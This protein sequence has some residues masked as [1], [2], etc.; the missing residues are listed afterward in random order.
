[1]NTGAVRRAIA[2]RI[3]DVV[4]GVQVHNHPPGALPHTPAVVI[5][6]QSYDLFDAFGDAAPTTRWNLVALCDAADPSKGDDLDDL[7]DSIVDAMS[8]PASLTV[9]SVKVTEVGDEDRIDVG[10]AW[11]YAATIR[12]EVIT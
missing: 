3:S 11:Y 5:V 4:G 6:R 12:V 8:D 10:G 2:E 1:M 9:G 7:V